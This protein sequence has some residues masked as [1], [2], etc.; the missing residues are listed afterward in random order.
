MGLIT[1]TEWLVTRQPGCTLQATQMRSVSTLITLPL[2]GKQCSKIGAAAFVPPRVQ[3]N[4]TVYLAPTSPNEACTC[5]P[6]AASHWLCLMAEW[7]GRDQPA[8]IPEARG[9]LS[10]ATTAP[11]CSMQANSPCFPACGPPCYHSQVLPAPSLAQGSGCSVNAPRAARPSISLS[12]CVLN[13]SS[14]E[15][16][17]RAASCPLYLSEH[18]EW[19]GHCLSWLE[20]WR[21]S[22]LCLGPVRLAWPPAYNRT[23]FLLLPVDCTQ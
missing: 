15:T 18:E 3:G 6:D 19:C 9:S 8:W 23:L 11:C 5:R 13:I 7:P 2:F 17:N 1:L 4:R 16:I 14:L 21:W 12:H 10:M 22:R 20:R